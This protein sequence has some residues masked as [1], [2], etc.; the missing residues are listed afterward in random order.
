VT[1]A[2]GF[3]D[4]QLDLIAEVSNTAEWRPRDWDVFLDSSPNPLARTFR[5]AMRAALTSGEQEQLTGVL[6]PQVE[7]GRGTTRSARAFLTARKP[8]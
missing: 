3:D 7:E 4:I 8:A 6:R 2:A 1:A 5:E